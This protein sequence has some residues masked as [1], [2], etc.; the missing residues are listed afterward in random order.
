MAKLHV[1]QAQFGDSLILEFGTTA[2]PKFILIDGGPAGVYKNHL[3]GEILNIIGEGG[4]LEAVM[5]SHIDTDHIKGVLDL[6]TEI[7]KQRDQE[8]P[9]LLSVKELWHNSFSNT[10]DINGSVV[11]GLNQICDAMGTMSMN[12]E[13]ASMIVNSQGEANRV[14]TFAND[15]EIP[16][17]SHTI[18]NF[19]SLT[20][21]P[22]PIDFGG[23][24][25]TVIG[26]TDENLQSLR[27]EWVEW[28]TD[29][30][31]EIS[32]GK[33]DLTAYADDTAPNLSSI[34]FVA[35]VNNT[36]I[37]FTG[38]GR[39]DHIIEGLKKRNFLKYGKFHVDIIKVPHHG[40][41]RNTSREFF[42]KITA[43]KYVISA[44]GKNK[45][46]D[47]A[48]LTWIVEAAAGQER[49]IE[50]IVTNDTAA[51]KKIRK[52]YDQNEYK[53]TMTF[54]QEDSNSLFIDLP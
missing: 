21:T 17:N 27:D 33:F 32:D 45:N 31:Q 30:M 4:T 40:S 12:M 18:N 44:N 35:K 16:I 29:R 41:D 22:D 49:E 26:P 14:R 6:L 43:D 48:T 37:L 10:I 20:N 24:E 34:T 23:V 1:I 38:D 15:L 46:P 13:N 9:E 54:I 36:T 8:K 3:R 28:L 25:L 51:T 5:V 7:K 39:G 52:D 2:N 53:Y 19:F 11:N 47:Y 42:E 50:I